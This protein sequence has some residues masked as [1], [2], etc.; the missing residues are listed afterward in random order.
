MWAH[1]FYQDVML[2]FLKMTEEQFDKILAKIPS[3]KIYDDLLSPGF[4]RAGEVLATVFDLGN[5]VLLPF[6]LV[7]ERSKITFRRNLEIYEKK[8]QQIDEKDLCEVPQQIGLP[9]IDKL[10]IV[11]QEE[12]S[13]AFTNLLVKASSHKTINIVHPAFL[14][15]LNDISQDEAILLM[16]L[17][18]NL[19]HPFIDVNVLKT[20]FPPNPP[21]K[22][23]EP[24]A[25]TKEQ[26]KKIMNY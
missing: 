23:G 11:N 25:K 6:K 1:S 14:N 24:G 12:L 7:N 21:E 13:H 26:L 3:D 15:T 20:Q 17:S 19:M 5:L 10:T 16:A 2:H 8:L 9:I 22:Y 18:D 4:K